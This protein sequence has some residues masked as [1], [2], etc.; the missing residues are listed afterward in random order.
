[1]VGDV[2]DVGAVVRTPVVD[3]AERCAVSEALIQA[4]VGVAVVG[5]RQFRVYD[6]G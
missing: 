5:R 3:V 1:M 4:I 6:D 2:V